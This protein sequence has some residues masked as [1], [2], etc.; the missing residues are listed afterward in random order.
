LSARTTVLGF[1][2][3]LRAQSVK[4]STSYDPTNSYLV[5]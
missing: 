5:S 4:I 3:I 1:I 2:R